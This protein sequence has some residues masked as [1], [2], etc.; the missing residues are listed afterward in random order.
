MTTMHPRFMAVEGRPMTTAERM[1]ALAS[2]ARALA[3]A[4]VTDF[5][6]GVSAL[7]AQAGQI[8][9]GGDA[10]PQGIREVARR[11]GLA[12]ERDAVSM[13]AIIVRK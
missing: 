2:Q 6:L 11:L 4:E 3:A 10:Y 12:L 9:A 8:A 5:L 7:A 1:E 13:N